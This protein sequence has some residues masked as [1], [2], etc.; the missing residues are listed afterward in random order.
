M[1][2]I[3]A[4]PVV[5]GLGKAALWGLGTLGV[6][7]AAKEGIDAYNEANT[8][9]SDV[10]I[11]TCPSCTGGSSTTTSNKDWSSAF[12]EEE[13]AAMRE[14][15]K[16]DKADDSLTGPS[17]TANP[18]PADIESGTPPFP[19]EEQNGSVLKGGE[20]GD[21]DINSTY[22]GGEKPET[23]ASDLILNSE[24]EIIPKRTKPKIEDG[25]SREGWQHI[26]ER[27]VTGNSTRGPGD[28][29]ADGT[30]R[31]QVENAADTVVTKGVRISKPHKQMQTY[32]KRVKVNG[33]ADRVRVIVDS[34][35]NNR[36][37][38]AFPARSK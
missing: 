36:V 27:H 28:L 18:N 8:E 10:D 21:V 16:R 38:T 37:I 5:V 30:T 31:E 6:G 33:Q 20:Q 23:K 32:E 17:D 34:A 19:A 13:L 14:R 29:F 9:M 22:E 7:V 25:N 3:V 4:E 15:N 11:T 12:S 26:D 35:D 24:G 2:A 1:V